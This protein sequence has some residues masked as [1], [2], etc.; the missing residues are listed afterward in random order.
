MKKVSTE[1]NVCAIVQ[2]ALI[3]QGLLYSVPPS[4]DTNLDVKITNKRYIVLKIRNGSNFVLFI[5]IF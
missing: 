4:R 2:E 5:N 3:S 1:V